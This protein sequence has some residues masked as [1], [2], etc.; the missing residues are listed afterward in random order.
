M[1]RKDVLDDLANQIKR[2]VKL[3]GIENMLI[4][5]EEVDDPLTLSIFHLTNRKIIFNVE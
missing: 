2:T 3:I 5:I 1:T 4:V